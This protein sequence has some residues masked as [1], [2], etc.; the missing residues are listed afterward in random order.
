MSE[1]SRLVELLRRQFGRWCVGRH[2][3][4]RMRFPL[5][6]L[7]AMLAAGCSIYP[8]PPPPPPPPE[9]GR[10][11]ALCEATVFPL[12]TRVAAWS[13]DKFTGR[14]TR[15][16]DALIVARQEHRLLVARPGFGTREI[17]AP[18]VGSWQWH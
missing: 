13:V 10:P 12:N 16:A 18:D 2:M 7:S 5:I 15:G 3:E 14:Y 11:P 1:H 8:H 6:A 4:A 9:L 17:T